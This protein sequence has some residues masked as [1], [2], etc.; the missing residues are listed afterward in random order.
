MAKNVKEFR[1]RLSW[2]TMQKLYPDKFVLIEDPV[3][4][5]DIHLKEGI[6]LYK[7]MHYINVVKKELELNPNDSIIEYT[8]GIRLE[9]CKN[10]NW[11]V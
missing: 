7:N 5:D 2:E 1:Q 8:G 6:F 4:E 11:V 10:M 9:R 3:F